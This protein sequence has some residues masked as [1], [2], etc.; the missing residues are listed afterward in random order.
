[1]SCQGACCVTCGPSAH[2]HP[3][4]R[5]LTPAAAA[6][7]PCCRCGSQQHAPPAPAGCAQTPARGSCRQQQTQR[8]Q[9]SAIVHCWMYAECIE[10]E[11]AGNGHQLAART[12]A[13]A[14]GSCTAATNPACTAVSFYILQ[15]ACKDQQIPLRSFQHVFAQAGALQHLLH[16][17]Q[18]LRRMHAWCPKRVWHN[19]NGWLQQ[20]PKQSYLAPKLCVAQIHSHHA[21]K[22][23]SPHSAGHISS[24]TMPSTLSITTHL[25]PRL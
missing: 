9:P 22:C 20:Q 3:R 10:P 23:R 16:A 14:R 13:P 12:P 21:P 6:G 15:D 18:Q 7:C 24:A 2:P 4:R 11:H 1:M 8:I 17:S 25:D 19:H 5:L